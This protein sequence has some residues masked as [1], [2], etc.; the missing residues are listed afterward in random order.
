PNKFFATLKSNGAR[1]I[2][3]HSFGDHHRF[4][5]KNARALLKEADEKK[6]MLVT[7]EKDWARIPDEDEDSALTELKNRSRPFPI[8][9][10]FEDD[11][12][13]KD[14]LSAVVSR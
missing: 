9:V 6:A 13:A 10:T 8:L 14:L 5:E 4:T 12:Q 11:E 1:L 7:T 2:E 3:S